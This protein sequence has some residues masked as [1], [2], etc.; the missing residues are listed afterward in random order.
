M[1]KNWPANAGDLSRYAQMKN[2]IRAKEAVVDGKQLRELL[3]GG[4]PELRRQLKAAGLQS[5]A[6]ERVYY[7]VAY[8]FVVLKYIDH[9]VFHRPM[10]VVNMLSF[11]SAD[12]NAA[13]EK[14]V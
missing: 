4:L 13:V 12:V 1:V 6:V 10:R 11:T 14:L 2:L 8:A 7:Q 5:G 3:F 9:D